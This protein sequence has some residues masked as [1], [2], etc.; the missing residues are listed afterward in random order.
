MKKALSLLLA[1][2]IC[3]SLCA[4]G[5]DKPADEDTNQTTT[6]TTQANDFVWEDD[7]VFNDAE[8][9]WHRVDNGLAGELL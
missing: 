6:T 4:C 9:A 7:S 1:L 8:I 3:L 2:V 5:G